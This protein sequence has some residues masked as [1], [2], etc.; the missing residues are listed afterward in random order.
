MYHIYIYYS[1]AFPFNLLPLKEKTALSF[2]NAMNKL[3]F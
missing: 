1:E 2:D 3:S